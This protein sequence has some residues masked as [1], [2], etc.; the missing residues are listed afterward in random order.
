MFTILVC[1]GKDYEDYEE[2]FAK[3]GQVCDQHKLWEGGYDRNKSNKANCRVIAAA[4]T[5]VDLW[6]NSWANTYD[7][8]GQVFNLDP[9]YGV[10]AAGVRNAEMIEARPDL[11]VCF[12][13]DSNT[14]DV[15]GRAYKARIAVQK[16]KQ[17]APVEF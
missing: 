16:F 1:G 12:G 9:Q 3:L 17:S 15:L 13:Q 4:S 7:A 11:V 8:T 10:S 6:A 5:P 2:V 14:A